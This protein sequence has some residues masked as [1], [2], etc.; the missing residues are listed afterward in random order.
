MQ[1]SHV[2][3]GILKDLRASFIT[4]PTLWKSRA[5]LEGARKGDEV[6]RGL[7][8][9]WQEEVRSGCAFKLQPFSRN[10]HRNSCCC[11]C[12]MAFEMINNLPIWGTVTE[13][14]EN[15]VNLCQF[16]VNSAHLLFC[17]FWLKISRGRKKKSQNS[18]DLFWR[19]FWNKLPILNAPLDYLSSNPWQTWM[20]SHYIIDTD[21]TVTVHYTCSGQS[22]LLWPHCGCQLGVTVIWTNLRSLTPIPL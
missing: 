2:Y 16:D 18:C 11:S 3:Y 6:G 14:I 22:E 15:L 9:K 10:G 17:L 1:K 19:W 8:L 21:V 20:C 12:I 13:H 7:L 4:S 5:Y